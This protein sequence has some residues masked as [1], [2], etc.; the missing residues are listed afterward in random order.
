[1]KKKILMGCSNYWSSPFQVGSHHIARAFARM[2]WDVA[3]VSDPISPLHFLGM[4]SESLNERLALYRSKLSEVEPGIRAYVPATLLPPHSKPVLRM[5]CIHQYWQRYTV[6]N[7]G[8]VLKE[9]GFDNVD[10]LYLDNPIHAG[11]LDSIHYDKSMLR[12]ADK[13]SGFRK[14]TSAMGVLEKEVAQRVDLVAYTAQS[15]HSHVQSLSPKRSIFLPN[16]VNVDH[17]QNTKNKEPLD[18]AQIPHPRVVYVGAMHEWFDFDLINSSVAALPNV[19]FILIGPNEL[20]TKHLLRAP[21]LHLLGRRSYTSLPAYLKFSDIGIIPFNV[22]E[23]KDLIEHVNPLKLLEYFACG[24]PVVAIR[25]EELN[26]FRDIANLTERNS[27]SAAIT[28]LLDI[29]N[30]GHSSKRVNFAREFDWISITKR[31]VSDI[32]AETDKPLETI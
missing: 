29:G 8:K 2:G 32:D 4:P 26:R 22:K 11:L 1:M 6:P 3:F 5:K 30:D 20:A 21:N 17:F 23:H 18:I 10:I 14:Y 16:G 25:W 9:H 19:S 31:L 12:I 13:M 27:F 15:L 28:N 7:I 24:L